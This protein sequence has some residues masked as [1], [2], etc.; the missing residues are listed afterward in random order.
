MIK[1]QL[2]YRFQFPKSRQLFIPTHNETLSIVE[3]SVCNPNVRPLESTAETQPQLHPALLRLSAIID[4]ARVFKLR[5]SG[6]A[7]K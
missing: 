2:N 4:F 6:D 7:L 1:R 3:T 5:G